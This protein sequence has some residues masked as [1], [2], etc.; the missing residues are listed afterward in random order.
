MFQNVCNQEKAPKET[1]AEYI[2]GAMQGVVIKEFC[3]YALMGLFGKKELDWVRFFITQIVIR[4][5]FYLLYDHHRGIYV[6]SKRPFNGLFE[7]HIE[8]LV[9]D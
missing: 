1:P 6:I 5:S 9:N 4:N 3:K 2:I 8:I 7:R